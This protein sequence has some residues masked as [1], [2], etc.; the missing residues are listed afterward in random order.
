MRF[1]SYFEFKR[2]YYVKYPRG[3]FTL[4]KS[5]CHCFFLV[6]ENTKEYEAIWDEEDNSKAED[7]IINLIKQ[8]N[9]DMMSLELLRN[10]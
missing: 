9:W 3:V 8:Y 2:V 10:I 5:F 1:I 6:R 4:G 7:L